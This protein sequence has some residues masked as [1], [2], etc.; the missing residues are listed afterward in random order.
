MIWNRKRHR[1]MTSFEPGSIQLSDREVDEIVRYQGVT[2]NDVGVLRHF[3]DVC[4][5]GIDQVVDGFYD[6]VTGQAQPRTLLD[7]HTTTARQ[8]PMLTK[9]L[10]TLFA[11]RID[12]GYIEQRRVVGRVHQRIELPFHWYLGMYE[13]LRRGFVDLVR[14]SDASTDDVAA[15]SESLG[16]LLYLDISLVVGALEE[17]RMELAATVQAAQDANAA[18]MEEFSRVLGR[19]QSGDLTAR[20]PT[21]ISKDYDR[22]AAALNATVASLADAFRRVGAS[23][24][25]VAAAATQ[26]SKGSQGLAHSA[27][28]QAGNLQQITDH[29]EAMLSSGRANRTSADEANHLSD[30]ASDEA[31]RGLG[32]MRDLE[33]SI[34][35]IKK[36]S[37]ETARI[38]GTIDEIAFQTNLLAL[39]AA[40]E[41]AR[42]GDAGKGFAV[43]A[44]EVRALAI[45]SA[46]SARSTAQLIEASISKSA[47]VVGQA[48]EVLANFEAIVDRNKSVSSLI[49]EIA[50]SSQ[51]QQDRG[52]HLNEAFRE[53]SAATQE[54]AANAEESAASAEQ[55][56]AQAETMRDIVSQFR[57]GDAAVGAHHASSVPANDEFPMDDDWAALG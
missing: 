51:S 52:E 35:D 1:G 14:E 45:R 31:Q 8:R 24:D 54:T 40:V 28:V 48:G 32:G 49:E 4:L 26:I 43:V 56:N 50:A 55:L 7:Q 47:H 21:G 37:D 3:A 18:F 23:S 41:A 13:V 39:N 11:G 57:V 25:E 33:G 34:Q 10:R 20:V 44:E 22:I 12:D 42:A 53:L 9:Y 36:S 16:R 5:D 38:V 27:S 6:H 30:Q 29:V 2:P 17:S 19:V 15:F 46:E